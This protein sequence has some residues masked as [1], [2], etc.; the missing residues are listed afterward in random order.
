M[1]MIWCGGEDID[2]LQGQAPTIQTSSSTFRSAYARCGINNPPGSGSFIKSD[3]FTAQTSCWLSCQFAGDMGDLTGRQPYQNVI[4]FGQFSS[5][6]CLSIGG[7]PSNGQKV[8]LYKYDGTTWTQLAA[9]GGASFV[10]GV[11]RFDIQL[12]SYGSS[13]TVNVYCAGVQII[14]FTGDVSVSGMS[15]TDCVVMGPLNTNGYGVTS[16][17]MVTS[18]DSRAY[19]GLAT[20]AV[21]N[22]GTTNDWTNNTYTNINGINYSDA[23][24]TFSNTNGQDQQYEMNT[25]PSGSFAIPAVKISA[26]S[27]LGAGS[28]VSHLQLGY[29]SGGSVGFGSG[30]T[31]SPSGAYANLWQLDLTNPVI[32]SAWT[33]SDV[34]S[35]QV[36][37]RAET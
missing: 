2:F 18:D 16:E 28:A 10:S 3:Q 11:H 22:Q 4:G 19:L 36:D 35:L 27:A 25:L 13:A 17:I 24:P 12:I 15:N 20:L 31:K 1:S 7:N 30:S 5:Q 29:N 14:T 32:S 8:T 6:N 37:L 21:N 23:N 9:E 26:R 34:N 33:I